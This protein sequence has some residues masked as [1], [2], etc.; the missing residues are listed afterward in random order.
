MPGCSGFMLEKRSSGPG[1]SFAASMEK[2]GKAHTGMLKTVRSGLASATHLASETAI[3]LDQTISRARTTSWP[4]A[5]RVPAISSSTRRANVS[6]SRWTDSLPS[7]MVRMPTRAITL[8][9]PLLVH[10][11][12]PARA[13]HPQVEVENDLP[14]LCPAVTDPLEEELHGAVRHPANGL[15]QG[16]ERRIHE[17]RPK[18]VVYAH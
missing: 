3:R 7:D 18:R 8:S 1:V 12:R 6:T 4:A 2:C 5:S 10:T 13:A 16:R 14:C 15:G 11:G 9:I 17:L